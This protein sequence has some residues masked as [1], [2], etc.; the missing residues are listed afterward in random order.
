[1]RGVRI[2][3]VKHG[4]GDLHISD[5]PPLDED[6]H[7]SAVEAMYSGEWQSGQRH[8]TGKEYTNVGI[9]T[10]NYSR[11]QRD[12]QGSFLYGKGD[13]WSGKFGASRAT[14]CHGKYQK[15]EYQGSLLRSKDYLNFSTGAEHGKGVIRF[16]DGATYKYIASLFFA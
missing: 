2:T 16:A 8:G 3:R 14:Y 11:D 4:L 7:F 1:M 10:G 5:I 9:Y 12:G 13:L 6:F 15:E